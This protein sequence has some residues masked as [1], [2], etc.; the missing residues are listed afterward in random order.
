MIVSSVTI[1]APT[2]DSVTLGQ[3]TTGT[4]GNLYGYTLSTFTAD[5]APVATAQTTLPL[6]SGGVV[7]P[8]RY[9]LRRVA[10]EGFIVAR[11]ATEANTLRRQLVAVLRDHEDAL[12]VR[13]NVEGTDRSLSASIDG[14]VTFEQAGGFALRFT[15]QLVSADPAAYATA[16]TTATAAAAGTVLTNPGDAYVWP[17][18][19]VVFSGACSSLRIG[20]STTGHYIQLDGLGATTGQTL[21]ITTRPGYEIV[22]L[23]GVPV[24][25][26]LTAASRFWSLKPGANTVYVTN[27]SGGSALTVAVTW[28][29]GW[30]S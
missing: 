20:N 21:E 10:V 25:S 5:P 1:T 17:D 19:A 14:A 16:E 24:L 2:G 9:G 3:L 30:V 28:R 7:V 22:E 12:T 29:A 27:L 15:A 6:V 8:G 23:N 11:T 18:M 13:W 4:G 26:K